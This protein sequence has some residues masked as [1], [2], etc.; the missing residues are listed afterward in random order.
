[1]RFGYS[2]TPNLTGFVEGDKM[3]QR[4][5]TS[6]YDSRIETLSAGLSSDLISLFRGE[7]Y[8]GYQRQTSPQG[9][10]ATAI[11]PTVGVSLHYYPT[12]YLTLSGTIDRGFAF[13]AAAPV[14]AGGGPA[15]IPSVW[16]MR[17]SAD[18]A[19]AAYWRASTSFS[20]LRSQSTLGR[21]TAWVA[22]GQFAYDFWRNIDLTLSYQYA[23]LAASGGTLTGYG[24]NVAT[25][26]LTY[27]Y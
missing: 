9:G 22:G 18:Y 17:L 13:S 8:V 14:T 10:F 11:A 19:F 24:Q 6:L 15:A 26:G 4:R 5:A 21:Q 1:L 25:L 23:R 7:A 2:L 12:T 16:Q 20:W 27:K 3:W